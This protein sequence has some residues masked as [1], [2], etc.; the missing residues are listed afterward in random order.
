MLFRFA[1]SGLVA[2]AGLAL[3]VQTAAAEAPVETAIKGWVA[4]IDA[5]P[6]WQATYK[7][8]DL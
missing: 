1:A 5:S 2:G 3:F 4:S 8:L 6:D 7:S